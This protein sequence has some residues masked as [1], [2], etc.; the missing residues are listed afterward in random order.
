MDAQLKIIKAAVPAGLL[1]AGG[2]LLAKM[3]APSSNFA[4]LCAAALGG[5][6]G[7]AVSMNIK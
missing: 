5:I 2:V 7:V 1:A 4:Q 6:A 3:L